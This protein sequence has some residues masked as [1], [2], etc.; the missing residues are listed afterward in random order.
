MHDWLSECEC[1]SDLSTVSA[2]REMMRGAMTCSISSFSLSS[3]IRVVMHLFLLHSM[4]LCQKAASDAPTEAPVEVPTSPPYD[5]VD[6]A[7]QESGDDDDS[8]IHFHAPSF[9]T[10]GVVVLIAVL[11]IASRYIYLLAH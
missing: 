10:V 2:Q 3:V 7:N 6:D 5:A 1:S 11:V 8:V 4:V 9:I